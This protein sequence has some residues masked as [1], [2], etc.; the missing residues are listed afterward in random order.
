M[1]WPPEWQHLRG[2]FFYIKREYKSGN[3]DQSSTIM[4]NMLYGKQTAQVRQ[5]ATSAKHGAPPKSQ[6]LETPR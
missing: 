6:G 4:N 5:S 1:W 2:N 3:D